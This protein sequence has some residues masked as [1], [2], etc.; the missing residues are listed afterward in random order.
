SHN[1]GVGPLR[2]YFQGPGNPFRDEPIPTEEWLTLSEQQ[3]RAI[4]C[5]PVYRD[6]TGELALARARLRWYPHD[7]WLYLLASMWKRVGQEE[8]FPGRCG[9]VGDEVGALI[10]AGRLAR[11]LMRL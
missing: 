4:V 3:L 7:V 8:A 1:V 6:D 5:G 2:G 11:D 10:V 9:D